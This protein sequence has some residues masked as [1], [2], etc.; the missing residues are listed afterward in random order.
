MI[1]AQKCFSKA[2][3]N[4]F[5]QKKFPERKD[6]FFRNQSGSGFTL[7]ELLV[8][9]AIIAI[10]AALLL[11]ALS[12]A[13]QTA[14]KAECAS[15]LKQWGV[16]INMYAGE[17]GDYF[18]DNTGPGA[19]DT[20][21]MAYSMNNFFYPRYLYNNKAG[22]A[23]QQRSQNDVLYCPTD[24]W[25]RPYESIGVTNLIGYNY[26][27]GRLASAGAYNSKGLQGWFTRNKLGGPFRKAPVMMDKLEQRGTGAWGDVHP[28]TG[29]YYPASNHVGNGGV[30]R[31][32]NFLYDDGHVDWL[33]FKYQK[34][35]VA[36]PVSDIEIGM[37][38][39]AGYWIN[40]LKPTE[41][42]PGPW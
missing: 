30:P 6:A 5:L 25:H 42:D 39:A 40:Y 24:L 27:P 26:L 18:P 37:L 38:D 1:T 7:I 12:A 29:V 31:G 16:A 11:P 15:N 23:A 41:L 3:M 35:L 2:G 9:I 10:L 33:L 36:A 19:K 22:T 17:N 32:G 28:V 4:S 8:V 34:L 20:A 14:Y 21:W 13:K